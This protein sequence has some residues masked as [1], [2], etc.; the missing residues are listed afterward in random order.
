MEVEFKNWKNKN[1]LIQIKSKPYRDDDGNVKYFICT[2][3]GVT[4]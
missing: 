2:A 1:R 3:E 4:K